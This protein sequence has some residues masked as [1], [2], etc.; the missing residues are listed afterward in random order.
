M[1]FVRRD[2]DGAL[3]L[4]AAAQAPRMR[5]GVSV[6][7]VPTKNATALPQADQPEAVVVAVTRDGQIYLEVARV[8]PD[9]LAAR[10][11]AGR[12]VFVK[13]DAD[14]PPDAVLYLKLSLK[15]RTVLERRLAV[16]RTTGGAYAAVP[17]EAWIDE[18]GNHQLEIKA[19]GTGVFLLDRIELRRVERD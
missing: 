8:G 2:M 18:P 15:G 17:F 16:P 14:A 10:L 19:A 7:M 1:E 12:P 4:A 9:E 13:A 11:P 6:R 5:A 3:A